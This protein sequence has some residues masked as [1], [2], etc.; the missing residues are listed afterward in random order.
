[1]GERDWKPAT[2]NALADLLTWWAQREAARL[3]NAP[4]AND[5]TTEA[6]TD[7]ARPGVPS[8]ARCP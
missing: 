7:P 5:G 3:K 2:V 4:A 8:P 6:S 1:M